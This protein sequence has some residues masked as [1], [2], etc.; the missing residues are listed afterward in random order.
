MLGQPSHLPDEVVGS[1]GC[2]LELVIQSCPHLD[3]DTSSSWSLQRGLFVAPKRLRLARQAGKI[4]PF[5]LTLQGV[6]SSQGR[7]T[8]RGFR[9]LSEW[10]GCVEKHRSSKQTKV[11][12]FV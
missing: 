5:T 7:L 8:P 1:E 11:T 4:S 3:G 10:V 9:A 6:D 12:V 2:A